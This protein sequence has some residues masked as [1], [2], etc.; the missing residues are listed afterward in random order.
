[1]YPF[2]SNIVIAYIFDLNFFL[3]KLSPI[4]LPITLIL[5]QA[6]HAV[7]NPLPFYE[8]SNV[9]FAYGGIGNDL[10]GFGMLDDVELDLSGEIRTVAE[11]S[12]GL[13][14]SLKLPL[15]ELQEI[16]QLPVQYLKSLGYEGLIA[17]PDPNQI[18]PVTGQD[19][20]VASDRSLRIVV[21]VSRV[22]S[23]EFLNNGINDQVFEKLSKLGEESFANQKGQ[24][25]PLT[26]AQ[27]RY[28]KR[29]G[30]SY[31][32]SAVTNLTPGEEPGQ[33][34]PV[35]KLG[36]SQKHGGSLYASNAGT[37]TTGK[38]LVGGT[39]F[40]NQ[41]SERDDDLQLSYISSDTRER[42][43]LNIKYKLP[44]LA[45]EILS[46]D[47]Q[48]GYSSYDASS[49]ALTR[50][51]FEGETRSIDL[52]LRWNPLETEHENY[53]FGFEFGLRGEKV[54]AENSLING[55]ADADMLTPRLAAS[56]MTQGQYL[57]TMTKI[58]VRRNVHKIPLL[59]R[60]L[61]GGVGVTDRSTRLKINYLE[62]IKFGKWLRN[63][64]NLDLPSYWDRH[65]IISRFSADLGLED[66]RHLPQHQF[67]SGGTGSVRGYPESPIA[68]D[69]GYSMSVEYR[70]PFAAGDAGP[71]LGKVSS[72]LI[73]FIDW[74]ETFV[75]DPLSYES[76]QSILGSGVGLEMKFSKGLQA[77]LDFAKPL[78]EI[79]NG[80]TIVDGTR[81]SDNRVHAL[82]VWEF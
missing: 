32:R 56:L 5:I 24:G 22:E 72:T 78:R 55:R 19:L 23:V 9:K 57:R 49:F 45:P 40:Y 42:E 76:D 71:A 13:D 37:E 53:Q 77:R 11:L 30:K 33:V 10:P 54:E 50:I 66:E 21:W 65:L 28:W 70:I 73:P 44:L 67:I 80:G 48:A 43:A 38:W 52:A 31:S 2:F 59:D 69:D 16:A 14:K 27:L 74:A 61:L 75:T 6:G 39:Y 3:R 58:E 35:V 26:N 4:V 62:S 20:R 18:D 8:V 41:I 7:A 36:L 17:F 79:K 12:R 15:R 60:S 81:S 29:Y 25:K 47:V 64:L 82:V 46:L 51:D 63:H 34:I 1:M 68:G